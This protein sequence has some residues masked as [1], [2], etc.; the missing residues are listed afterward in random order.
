M[1]IQVPKLKKISGDINAPKKKKIFLIADSIVYSSGVATAAKEI[2]VGTA[3]KY[4]WV[5][6]GAALNHPDHGKIIDLSAEIEKE[7]GAHDVYCKIY[8]HNGYGNAEVIRE[9]ISYERPD[10]LLLITD[11]RFF[12]HVFN[13]E[14]ELR[15]TYKIPIMYYQ[16]WDN[17]PIPYWNASAYAS[18]DLLMSINR[19]TKVINDVILEYHGTPATDIDIPENADKKDLGVI[20]S[21]VPHGSSTKYFY[22]QTPESPDWATYQEFVKNFKEKHDCDFVVFYNSRNIRRKQPGDVILAYSYMCDNLPPEVAKRCCL[23]MKTAVQDENGT[24]LQ[25]VKRTIC[26]KH[27][28][29]F[30]QDMVSTQTL[31]YFYNLADCTMFMSSAEGFGLAA[32]ESL[33]C[34]TMIVAPVT[35]GLQD[36]MRFHDSDGNWKK[37]DR[38][39][40]TNHR[41]LPSKGMGK[42]AVPLF[43]KARALQGSIPTPYIFD[44]YCDA[45]DAGEA[46]L[47]LHKLGKETRDEFGLLGR[48]WVL[49]EESGMSSPELCKRFIR[50]VECC[51]ANFKPKPKFE[52][53][54]VEERKE[55]KITGITWN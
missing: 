27:K 21:Y 10:A 11:P 40:P 30:V 29:I 43:P 4:D 18:C 16:I 38:N 53:K 20:L 15:S 42:W 7:S 46:L 13:M 25:A 41:A 23:I 39:F 33:M 52:I 14:H 35:G 3:H 51:L 48:E 47:K 12:G 5:Q 24:D 55:I 45:Q 1:Q 37:I 22:K 26:P 44:D 2:V 19:Q 49:S 32:N 36:Q 8:C 9:I 54:K 50:S 31:N 6:L 17:L 34:G 28:V